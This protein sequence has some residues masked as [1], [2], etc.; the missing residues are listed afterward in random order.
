M[1]PGTRF[2]GTSFVM[3]DGYQFQD[4]EVVNSRWCIVEIHLPGW[5][6]CA[7]MIGTG[8]VTAWNG[9]AAAAIYVSS[10][11]RPKLDL[12]GGFFALFSCFFALGGSPVKRSRSKFAYF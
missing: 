12:H 9:A 3:I 1:G 7:V 2:R 4:R 6:G 11:T 8:S 10:S 5:T